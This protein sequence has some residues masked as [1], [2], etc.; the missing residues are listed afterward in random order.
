M[1]LSENVENSN[2]KDD[3]EIFKSFDN[4]IPIRNSEMKEP[5]QTNGIR[6]DLGLREREEE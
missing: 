3:L 2:Q 4:N 1:V 6:E 5:E